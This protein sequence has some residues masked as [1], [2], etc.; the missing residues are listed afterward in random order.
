MALSGNANFQRTPKNVSRGTLA[1]SSKSQQILLSFW[2]RPS[3]I[4]IQM[5]S[6]I[7][8]NSKFYEACFRV[9]HRQYRR[10]TKCTDKNDGNRVA[11]TLEFIAR[12]APNEVITLALETLLEETNPFD[13]D[14]I[15]AIWDWAT[16]DTWNR[17]YRQYLKEHPKEKVHAR[18]IKFDGQ[19]LTTQQVAGIQA[20]LEPLVELRNLKFTDDWKALKGEPLIAWLGKFLDD[21]HRLLHLVQRSGFEPPDFFAL[22]EIRLALR[23]KIDATAAKC[24]NNKNTCSPQTTLQ[25]PLTAKMNGSSPNGLSI[26][27]SNSSTTQY[28]KAKNGTSGYP[29][30]VV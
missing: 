15:I 18:N 25:K 26:T 2:L 4:F 8:A 3:D 23:E 14:T 19:I 17:L 21:A 1:L 30:F 9:G 27:D 20:A 28:S 29:R 22:N 10:S 6:V 5:A 13:P 11:R 16:R 12:K 24:Y 7:L